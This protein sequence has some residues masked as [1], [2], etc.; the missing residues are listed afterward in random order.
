MA[1]TLCGCGRFGFDDRDGGTDTNEPTSTVAGGVS[2][3]NAHTCAI[4]DTGL[5]CWGA[6][7]AGQIATGTASTPVLNPTRVPGQWKR[8]ATGQQHTCAIDIAGDVWCWG[9]NDF[10]QLGVGDNAPRLVP[11]RVTLAAP[12][13]FLASKQTHTCVRLDPD[14][15]YCWGRNAEGELGIGDPF[16]PTSMRSSPTMPMLAA[17]SGMMSAG[18]AHTL[19]IHADGALYGAGRNSADEIGRGDSATSGQHRTFALIDAGPWRQAAGGQ[20]SSCAIR[21]DKSLWCWGSNDGGHLGLGDNVNRPTPARVGTDAWI[22]V[23][24]DVFHTCGLLESGQIAC[25][26]RT[27][28]GQLGLA[29]QTLVPTPMVTDARTDWFDVDVG[30]FDTCAQRRDGTVWCTGKNE[31][32]NAGLG[33]LTQV[34]AWTQVPIN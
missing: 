33:H 29:Q 9:G 27:I 17:T 24:T 26:G 20:N 2:A 6:N 22:D 10:G 18:Q 13:L 30:R 32:G 28:E 11:T 12:A 31:T 21:A 4:V 23:E 19:W 8:V 1:V 3:G 5:W 25:A 16:S 14:Q 34:N 15:M 7:D